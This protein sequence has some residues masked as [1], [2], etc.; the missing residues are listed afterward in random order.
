[1]IVE[2]EKYGRRKFCLTAFLLNIALLILTV[3]ASAQK[4]GPQG[5]RKLSSQHS[6]PSTQVLGLEE[7]A[8][9]IKGKILSGAESSGDNKITDVVFDRSNLT[10]TIWHGPKDEFLTGSEKIWL[11]NLNSNAINW[12]DD[13]EVVTLKIGSKNGSVASTWSS[14]K[15]EGKWVS[16]DKGY[17]FIQF[18]KSA[19]SNIADFRRKMVGALKHLIKLCGGIAES[20]DPF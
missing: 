4:S 16:G 17:A 14:I 2:V 8:E 3:N 10:L 7:T 20:K 15:S 18:S 9:Y 5:K 6:K 1:M 13:E 19:V 11:S 12:E